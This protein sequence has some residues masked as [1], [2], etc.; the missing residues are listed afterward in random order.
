[1][2][3]IK[4][5]FIK[6]KMN[7]DLD[8]RLM[9]NGEYRDALN[10]NVNKSEG[11]DVGALENV[12]G[13]IKLTS[14]GINNE[15]AEIIGFYMDTVNDSIYVFI[16]DYSDSSFNRLS[17]FAPANAFCCIAVLNLDTSTS[18]I[19]VRGNFLNFS[20]T[21]P[22]VGVS[23]LEELFFFTDNRNQPRKINTQKAIQFPLTYYTNED[24][25]SVAKYYP[26]KPLRFWKDNN[27]VIESTMKDVVSQFLPVTLSME[28]LNSTTDDDLF[29]IANPPGS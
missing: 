22:I 9:P 24:Q 11:A 17:N 27:G 28:V 15:K 5:T 7:K 14:F 23:M 16:T 19:L 20:K 2:A 4:N 21:H 18:T 1:M 29:Q 25:I 8:A 6:S 12:L 26:F 10:I 13:N 3:E